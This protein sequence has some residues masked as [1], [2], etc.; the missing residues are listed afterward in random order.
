MHDQQGDTPPASTTSITNSLP[1]TKT[2]P[3][4]QAAFAASVPNNT[5]LVSSD[6]MGFNFSL[7]LLTELSTF[8]RDLVTLPGVMPESIDLPSASMVGLDCVLTVIRDTL[9]GNKTPTHFFDPATIL[10]ALDIS[11]VYDL[12]MVGPI[13]M[14]S[15]S[16]LCPTQIF[17]LYALA[18]ITKDTQLARDMAGKILAKGMLDID[19]WTTKILKERHPLQLICLYELHMLRQTQLDGLRD[20]MANGTHVQSG[21]NNFVRPCSVRPCSS[22]VEFDGS[23][24]MMRSTVANAVADALKAS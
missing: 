6:G 15:F 24:V 13:L 18:V 4:L 12:P 3:K 9:T 21:L 2:G 22:S 7:V 8:F 23:F 16:R 17:P 14:S 11:D 19:P 10:E 5:T 1:V 20:D